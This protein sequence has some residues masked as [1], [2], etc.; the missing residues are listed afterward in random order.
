MFNAFDLFGSFFFFFFL[1]PLK[2]FSLS[3]L[4]RFPSSF[5]GM[6]RHILDVSLAHT[7]PVAHAP[8]RTVFF[9]SL[10]R[11]LVDLISYFGV[12]F[13]FLWIYLASERALIFC[14][15]S[16]VF[17]LEFVF[18]SCLEIGYLCT[19]FSWVTANLE[20]AAVWC[21]LNRGGLS[22]TKG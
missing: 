3:R 14:V 10:C 1:F 21:R 2:S 17:G 19:F 18:A 8:K 6:S 4:D 11:F 5:W 15:I 22:R 9:S 13:D 7:R 16:S 12:V 20:A